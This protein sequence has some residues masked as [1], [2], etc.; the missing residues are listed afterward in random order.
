MKHIEMKNFLLISFFLVLG[1]TKAGEHL[2]Y[3]EQ[4]AIRWAGEDFVFMSK[5]ETRDLALDL[6]K[7]RFD[8][9]SVKLLKR[10][11]G[12]GEDW[13][14]YLCNASKASVS[15]KKTDDGSMKTSIDN[16]KKKC[17]DRNFKIDTEEFGK[18]VLKLSK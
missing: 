6:C 3:G 11:F 16:A 12:G 8:S 5:E 14:I 17:L 9:G 15:P 13:D 18:C 2:F 1:C 7:T 4:V 10:E